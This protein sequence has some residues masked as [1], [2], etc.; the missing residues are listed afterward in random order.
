MVCA[1]WSMWWQG[2]AF[3]QG[4]DSA[5]TG[6]AEEEKF[7]PC[8]TVSPWQSQQRQI[9]MV[10]TCL[11]MKAVSGVCSVLA[12]QAPQGLAGTVRF[13]VQVIQDDLSVCTETVPVYPAPQKPTLTLP[14]TSWS[15]QPEK[16]LHC[17]GTWGL[18]WILHFS[19]KKILAITFTTQGSR[20]SQHASGISLML[21]HMGCQL[22]F[23]ETLLWKIYY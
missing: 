2:S 13:H 15:L 12:G 16:M 4:H 20:E 6:L 5:G 11:G 19:S 22:I 9:P 10:N 8:I 7:Q 17:T 23:R 3:Y 18:R 1:V 14:E 21:F